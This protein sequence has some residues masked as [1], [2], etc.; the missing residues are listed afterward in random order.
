MTVE[1]PFIPEHLF[2]E[3]RPLWLVHH[4]WARLQAIPQRGK[5]SDD[6]LQR[7]AMILF[8]QIASV[9]YVRAA[10]PAS[11]FTM[12]YCIDSISP[13]NRNVQWKN[14]RDYTVWIRIRPISVRVSFG[15]STHRLLKRFPA[16]QLNVGVRL[17]ANPRGAATI[18][19]GKVHGREYRVTIYDRPQRLPRSTSPRAAKLPP[20]RRVIH[21]D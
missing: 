6:Q 14:W 12:Q 18:L 5:L 11:S 20:P 10:S 13:S 8:T 1:Q 2:E 3:S 4:A 21:L 9:M 16:A 19:A 17:G 7:F 15:I